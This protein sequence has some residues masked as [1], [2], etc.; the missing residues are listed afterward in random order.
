MFHIG[1]EQSSVIKSSELTAWECIIGV[2]TWPGFFRCTRLFL[3]VWTLGRDRG[4]NDE[5][6][7]FFVP[8]GYYGSAFVL[9][10]ADPVPPDCSNPS[11]LAGSGASLISPSPDLSKYTHE[12]LKNKIVNLY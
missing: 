10:A 7:E 12:R 4:F 1:A 2:M 3:Y 9:K 6:T 5:G 8:P 11:A